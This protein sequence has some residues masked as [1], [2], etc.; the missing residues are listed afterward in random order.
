ML[1]KIAAHFGLGHTETL[2]GFKYVSRVPN[3]LF[4]FEEAIGYLV[5]PTIVRDKDAI[6]A[7]LAL[8]NL[9]YRL[10]VNGETL[11]DFS[12]VIEKTVGAFSS[13]RI[14]VKSDIAASH[15]TLGDLL[16]TAPPTPVGN[17]K[18]VRLDDFLHRVEEFS[19][20]DILRFYLS[21]SSRVIIRPSGT[22]PKVKIYIDTSEPTRADSKATL[23]EIELAP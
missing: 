8:L 15:Q 3:L 22:E 16:R 23:H 1:G 12:A 13:S 11:N 5:T 6:S 4:G 9:S 17:R 18:V 21:D 19:S 14:T 7:R 10:A 2:T 20:T